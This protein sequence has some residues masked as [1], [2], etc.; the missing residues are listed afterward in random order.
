ML[1]RISLRI[2]K[3]KCQE[4]RIQDQRSHK[5]VTGFRNAVLLNQKNTRPDT[6]NNCRTLDG[7]HSTGDKAHVLEC[8]SAIIQGEYHGEYFR[9][10]Q[11]KY[12]CDQNILI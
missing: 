1:D 2:V 11:W 8:V 4:Y 7:P 3:S 12:C 5:V 6:S 9:S 10:Q